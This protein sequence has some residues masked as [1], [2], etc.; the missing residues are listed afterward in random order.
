MAAECPLPSDV[1]VDALESHL[2]LSCLAHL[3]RQSDGGSLLP[4][5][6]LHSRN[7]LVQEARELLDPDSYQAYLQYS[8]GLSR[9]LPSY[10]GSAL[11]APTPLKG[12]G[13]SR[14]E[15]LAH[16]LLAWG[17]CSLW[18]AVRQ[19][20]GHLCF[21]KPRHKNMSDQPGAHSFT[22]GIFARPQ[23][24]GLC[25]ATLQHANTSKLLCHFVAHLCSSFRW[26]T[27]AIHLNY[28][29]PVHRDFANSADQSLLALLREAYGL[30]TQRAGTFRRPHKACDRAATIS[31]KISTSS[32]RQVQRGTLRRIGNCMIPT[33][34]LPTQF[35]PGTSLRPRCR[36]FSRKWA[37][38]SQST[39]PLLM[40]RRAYC[41]QY[42]LIHSPDD[43]RSTPFVCWV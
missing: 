37:T 19:V 40:P 38:S 35:A 20:V 27:L 42:C 36:G 28:S 15:I 30:R 14:A 8:L 23:L 5:L 43:V 21:E 6:S 39:R 2:L 3:R 31:Y 9:A 10:P 29:A 32:F 18:E 26:T 22:I 16:D 41:P 4:S 7:D 25:K 12:D 34:W 33:L 1:Y 13:Y 11:P 24:V 17:Q